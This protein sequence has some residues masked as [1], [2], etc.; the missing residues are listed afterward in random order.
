SLRPPRFPPRLSPGRLPPRWPLEPPGRGP[1]RLSP[2][3]VENGLLATRRDPPGLGIGR[4]MAL[5]GVGRSP[6]FLASP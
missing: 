1:G 6:D 2:P 5:P 3:P 4:G